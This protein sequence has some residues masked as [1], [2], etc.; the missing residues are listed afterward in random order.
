MSTNAQRLLEA[1]LTGGRFRAGVA[2]GRWALATPVSGL[3]WPY[4]DTW[5]AAAIRPNSPDQWL[6]RW[7][8][9]NYGSQASTGGFWDPGTG[10]F[11]VPEKWPKGR[12]GSTVAS[13]FKVAGW[14]APGRGF[15]HHYDRLAIP[16]HPW[17][18][19]AWN[20]TV[21]LTDFITLVYRW[22]NCG[23]YLGQ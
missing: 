5:I 21:K 20:P 8:V 14:A 11:L 7:N 9:D 13:V 18:K 15:Y 12:S 19:D 3:V 22:L 17:T 1:E 16:G 4:I 6:V 23:D 10:T 2:G